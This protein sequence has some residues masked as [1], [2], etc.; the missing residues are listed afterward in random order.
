MIFWL[1]RRILGINH[2]HQWETVEKGVVNEL[3]TPVGRFIVLRCSK[4]GDY[5]I[6]KLV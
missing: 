4:C 2:D 6:R 1:W 3:G 5:K